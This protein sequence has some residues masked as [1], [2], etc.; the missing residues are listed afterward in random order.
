MFRLCAKVNITKG[1]EFCARRSALRS[2]SLTTT[3]FTEVASL[4]PDAIGNDPLTLYG[5][6]VPERKQYLM[7]GYTQLLDNPQLMVYQHNNFA[8]S[9][10]RALQLAASKKGFKIRA[11]RAGIMRAALKDS[12]FEAMSPLFGGPAFV[13]YNATQQE[14]NVTSVA[15]VK[16]MY[17]ILSKQ[18]KLLFLGAKIDTLLFSK[19]SFLKL[20]KIGSL[21]QLQS[22]LLGALS[23]SGSRLTNLLDSESQVL[24]Q[25]LKQH[26]ETPQE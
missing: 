4:T 11:C 2:F 18:R 19:E 26:S 5:R 8:V 10:F 1:I 15:N 24:V 25:L 6:K 3:S 12:P 16:S 20:S 21:P 17:D 13:F 23:S 7:H 9:E 14:E 22:Q